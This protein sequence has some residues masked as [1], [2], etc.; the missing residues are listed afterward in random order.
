MENL[1]IADQI[2]NGQRGYEYHDMRCKKIS[3]KINIGFS[4]WC[5]VVVVVAVLCLERRK[6]MRNIVEFSSLRLRQIWKFISS[7]MRFG[8]IWTIFFFH[9]IEMH[10]RF[11][12][13]KN[14]FRIFDALCFFKI[15]IIFNEY[16][17]TYLFN[18]LAYSKYNKIS[19]TT[20]T[21]KLVIKLL[22]SFI[23]NLDLMGEKGEQK[24]KIKK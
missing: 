8:R 3:N 2:W 18:R 1:K 12:L 21:R 4:S 6:I 23:F 22:A 24:K 16:D 15:K 14:C 20:K 7:N 9:W 5:V 13:R 17:S 11:G 10:S 19:K